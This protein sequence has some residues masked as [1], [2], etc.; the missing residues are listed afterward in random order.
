MKKTL[1][2]HLNRMVT[3]SY[4]PKRMISLCPSITETLFELDLEE[5]IVGRTSFCIHPK[6]KVNGV[7]VIGGTKKVNKDQ[8]DLLA[9]DLIIAEK[10]E[11]PR[12]LVEGL[13]KKYP[14]FVF[15]VEN[16]E[17]ALIMIKKLG[18]ITDQS[19]LASKMVQ[20]IEL[21]YSNLPM[22][23]KMKAA[24]IIWKDPFMSAGNHTFIHSVL[25]KIGFENVFKNDPGRYPIFTL[26]DLQKESPDLVFL[27]SEPYPFN[28]K[29][30]AEFRQILRYSKIMLVD[31]ESFIWYGSRMIK[32]ADYLTK[33]VEEISSS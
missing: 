31:G 15:D 17:D 3:F 19:V 1:I 20:E 2:D 33:L 29:H 4:P 27:T 16:I 13:A 12:E 6:E 23:R 11:N 21:K 14:V 24:Y 9:P 30:Q 22:V 18:E 26:E 28:E 25:E 10:E 5:R 7:K 32:S 8:I